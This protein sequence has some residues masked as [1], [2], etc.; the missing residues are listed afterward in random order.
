LFLFVPALF[1][2]ETARFL[3]VPA[4][5]LFVP[6]QFLLVFT[7]V[8]TVSALSL[9]VSTRFLLVSARF[10]VKTAFALLVPVL[11]LFV[12]AR[13]LFPTLKVIGC[14]ASLFLQESP[15]SVLRLRRNPPSP[16][17]RRQFS[18]LLGEK[19]VRG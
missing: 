9:F 7:N 4:L 11:T 16:R 6:K 12:F 14:I 1:Q 3:F 10:Q 19:G 18:F 2:T 5:V 15:S 8:L 17:G 13:F